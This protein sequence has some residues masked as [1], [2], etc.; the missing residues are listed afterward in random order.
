MATPVVT[1]ERP[2]VTDPGP[3]SAG[4][5]ALIVVGAVATFI[6][7]SLLI[8]GSA[9]MW[10]EQQRDSDGYFSTDSEML[11][12]DSYVLSAPNLDVN[13]AGPDVLYGQ[14]LLGKIRIEGESSGPGGPL[15]LGIGPTNEVDQYLAGV[16]HD[17]ISDFDVDPFRVTYTEHPGDAPDAA[18]T[19]QS[20]WAVS[21]SG[22]GPQT[23]TWDVSAGDWTVVIMNA[24]GS[25]GVQAEL[26]VGAT[27]SVLQP[28]AIG[29][30]I[31]G[32]V[33]FLAGIAMI[34][35]PLVTRRA[36]AV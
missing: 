23:L 9:V 3:L 22:S 34:V 26:S 25:A 15:F 33:L 27:L 20:F 30:L 6:G 10:A 19:A 31:G 8:G 2:P 4:R 1:P 11:S 35:L 32:A 12:T 21:E 18:P 28:I 29:M 14:D 16:G 7:G 13:L 17:E 36:P 5:T 24:D